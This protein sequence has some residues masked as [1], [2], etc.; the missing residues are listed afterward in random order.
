MNRALRKPAGAL[1]GFTVLC[2]LAGL[3]AWATV[4]LTTHFVDVY[5]ENLRTGKTHTVRELKG[6]PYAV[7]NRGDGEAV[8][9]VEV[10]A[11]A[12]EDLIEPFEPIPDPAWIKLEPSELKIGPGEMGGSSLSISIPDDSDFEGRHYQALIWA[13]TVGTGMV[14]AGLKSRLRFSVGPGPGASGGPV[15]RR[16]HFDLSPRVL[17]IGPAKAGEL[18][19]LKKRERKRLK[20]TNVSRK[21]RVVVLSAVPWPGDGP[22]PGDYERVSGLGWVRFKPAKVKLR[23]GR[24]KKI[25]MYL[26]PPWSLK[27]RKVGFRVQLSLPSGTPISRSHSVF[28]EVE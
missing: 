24:S 10:Q 23:K 8:V 21:K 20:L 13:R 4:G 22:L 16:G 25:R 19:D 1:A 12:P 5:F 3:P 27:G 28:L 17:R 7:K 26:D 6:I 14:S 18:Y 9:R 2:L 11:P 15:R